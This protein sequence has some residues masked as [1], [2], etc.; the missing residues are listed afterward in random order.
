MLGDNLTKYATLCMS[1]HTRIKAY[2][3]AQLSIV[4]RHTVLHKVESKIAHT[5]P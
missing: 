1:D 5:L 4:V 3:Y 2:T